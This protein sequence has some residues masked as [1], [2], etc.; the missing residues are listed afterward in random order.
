VPRSVGE[1]SRD[2]M[3][4]HVTIMREDTEGDIKRTSPVAEESQRPP[5]A[6]FN[7]VSNDD[8]DAAQSSATPLRGGPDTSSHGVSRVTL[9][10][11]PPAVSASLGLFDRVQSWPR[12]LD[13]NDNSCSN[14]PPVPDTAGT[15]CRQFIS[16]VSLA[17]TRD[18]AFCPTLSS[19]PPPT[20]EDMTTPGGLLVSPG[21]CV[22]SPLTIDTGAKCRTATPPAQDGEDD[23]ATHVTDDVAEQ[24]AADDD[25][26]AT[27]H[28]TTSQHV[29]SDV[30]A[31]TSVCVDETAES[32][33]PS[34]PK[35]PR[36]RIVMGA[37][38]DVPVQSLTS[39]ASSSSLPYVVTID[40]SDAAIAAADQSTS[41]RPDN[42]TD[43]VTQSSASSPFADE[44][45]PSKLQ[46]KHKVRAFCYRI[47]SLSIC[48]Y[49]AI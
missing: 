26:T 13:N 15:S 44:S 30:E 2:S 40:N 28:V 11:S 39:P 35:I 22:M 5:R 24:R 33:S 48:R 49:F 18:V 41:P 9:F 23:A 17:G 8:D 45:A 1:P 7:D 38:G 25:V 31:T 42:V 32:S 36:L 10:H 19:P 34:P 16:A 20:L 6:E 3:T 21:G 43:E 14:T 46:H 4:S 12:V 37:Q 47:Y 29:T 27:L